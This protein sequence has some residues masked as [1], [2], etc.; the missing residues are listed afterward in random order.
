VRTRP[1]APAIEERLSECL[2]GVDRR[3]AGGI[4]LRDAAG[5]KDLCPLVFCSLQRHEIVQGRRSGGFR[6]S[7]D[8]LTTRAVTKMC[9]I[10]LTLAGLVVAKYDGVPAEFV[11]FFEMVSRSLDLLPLKKH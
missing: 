7:E 3:V 5:E 4:P 10:G 6:I 9:R 1:S 11:H 8:F 2:P